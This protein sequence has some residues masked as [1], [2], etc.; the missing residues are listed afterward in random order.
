MTP[1]GILWA[2]VAVQYV[3]SLLYV[4]ALPELVRW[5]VS[6]DLPRQR[7]AVLS[8]SQTAFAVVAAVVSLAFAVWHTNAARRSDDQDLGTARGLVTALVWGAAACLT[9]GW[10][11]MAWWGSGDS[12]TRSLYPVIM[13]HPI[14]NVLALVAALLGTK[15]STGSAARRERE[16]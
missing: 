7:D 14:G 8:G 6:S 1:R 11:A 16:R 2:Y 9:L 5:A 10:I 13:L 12:G 3:L 4:Y 15:Q